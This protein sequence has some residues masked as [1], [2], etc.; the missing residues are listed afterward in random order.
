M[1]FSHFQGIN[2]APHCAFAALLLSPHP[3][4]LVLD[5]LTHCG[6]LACFRSK[7]DHF[8]PAAPRK[9]AERYFSGLR[10]I[11]LAFSGFFTVVP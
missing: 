11:F 10:N 6:F 9:A 3:A 4:S 1:H 2:G 8:L 5:I 7:K